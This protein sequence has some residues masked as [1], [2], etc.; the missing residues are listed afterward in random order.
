MKWNPKHWLEINDFK[1]P[2][3]FLISGYTYLGSFVVTTTNT[4]N[5]ENKINQ[6]NASND[7]FQTTNKKW[8]K[9]LI[10][11]VNCVG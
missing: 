1:L 6:L 8:K 7:T 4:Y 3:E 2:K 11:I 10:W 5:K 9:I